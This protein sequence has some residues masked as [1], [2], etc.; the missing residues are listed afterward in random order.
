MKFVA[1]LHLHSHY[2][3]AT[4]KNL[5]L[6][7]LSKWAQL[8]GVQVVGTGDIAHPG[9][10]A[11]M[12]AKLEPAEA[13]LFRLKAEYAQAVQEEVPAACGGPV[14]F[15]LAGEISS[16]YKKHDQVRKV[17][18][19]IFAP[20]L[21]AVARIQI[22]LEKIGN[23]R[24]DGRP[25]LGLPSRDLLEIILAV[26]PDCYL[27]PAHIWTPW[28]SLLG[29][30]SGYDSVEECFE[31]LTPHIFALETGLSSDPPM[32]WR[33]SALDDY[34]LVSNS[35]AHSPQKLAREANLFETELSYPA[36]FAA[37]K[38][39][40]PTGFRGTIEFFPEEGKYHL[41]GHRKCN[42]CWEPQTTLQQQGL[43]PVCG[44]KVTVGVYHRVE[45]L[46][47]QPAGRRPAN[48]PPFHSLIPLPEVLSEIHGVGPNSKRVG[49][50]YET[51]LAKLGSELSILL[52]LP[53]ETITQ[54]G[55]S[56]L[57]E[58][59]RR[60][61]QGQIR[62]EGGFDGQYGRIKLFAEG[63]KERLNSQLLLFAPAS[64]RPAK[65]REQP[66][67]LE[68]LAEAEAPYTP[69]TAPE[70][71][72]WQQVDLLG[73][74]EAEAA[75]ADT[76]RPAK[77]NRQQ[78]AAA[79]YTDG[80]L[81]IT[82]GPGTGKTR[83]LTYRIAQLI[84]QKG[85]APEKMLAITFTNKAAAEMAGRLTALLGEPV[86]GQLTIKTFHAWGG[87]VLRQAGEQIGLSPTFAICGD[88]ERRALLADAEPDL[89]ASTLNHYLAQLAEAKN[90]LLGP[91][92]PELEPDFSRVYRRYE[93]RLQANQLVD[94]DDLILKTV[95]LFERCPEILRAYQDR[96][97]WISVD[98]YQDINLAQYRLLR[99]LTGPE[100]NLCV[101][102]DP[103]Q[104]IYGFRGADRGYFLR[105]EQDYP[106]A[107]T[108]YL[109]Q[110]YRSSQMILNAASQVIDRSADERERQ[111]WSDFIDQ[112]KLEVY[113]APTAAAEA[114]YVVHSIERMVGGTSYFSLDSGRVD[115]DG[116]GRSFA[117]FAVL[118]RLN[119]LN[120]PLLEAF[121][122]SGIPF[123]TAG[124]APFYAQKEVKTILAYLWF[125]H[126]PHSS[127]HLE[128]ILGAGQ[129]GLTALSSAAAQ[130]QLS[131]G[132]ALQRVDQ[133][134]ALPAKSRQ[135]LIDL[136]AF[137]ARLKEAAGRQP[138]AELIERV[139]QYRTPGQA[140]TE[141]EQRLLRNARPFAA[142]LG[143]F[144][145]TTM[146]ENETDAYDPRAD[147][148]SLMTLHAAKGL[149]FPVV[150][151]IGCEENL[152]P[153]QLGGRETDREEE[154]RLFYV[155]LT[156]AQ[157][158]LVLTQART[159]FLF[160]QQYQPQPSPFVNDIEDALKEI[161]RPARP[162]SEKEKPAAEQ[163]KLF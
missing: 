156:R 139:Q 96:W 159:R 63:E 101:I 149:E 16:I 77:L 50:A 153:Y 80:P 161:R 108:I 111:I 78:Q 163:L 65:K 130:H 29:S 44:K 56:L 162:K 150:F 128:T 147:R 75:P 71:E 97:P 53:L 14:R 28:F 69:Q 94:F 43:C 19:V 8:K 66:P 160:G 117:D 5:N 2:S 52:D 98:E 36:I 7:Q 134:P 137:L 155:G 126:N 141:A 84:S 148:V 127:P 21:Q 46:A 88:D 132:E 23:I 81:I 120:R 129:T 54:A 145:E 27:I 33:V 60:M 15:M 146:L 107:K 32:N 157:Q 26:D 113:Q 100:S 131:L 105:F 123:Q 112:T 20:S 10:L 40:D 74:P 83:T 67:G 62:A 152:L 85:V 41:D 82:A 1:D 18:N 86:A 45:T 102:G 51:L 142:R 158:K 143:A 22:E 11:E 144:L 35:D 57:A 76:V 42:I 47:D 92:G 121:E 109:R 138:V 91:D 119:A 58:G 118:Y 136:A 116:A 95:R 31:D 4:S 114:E 140:P 17:H 154:R 6:E 125:L 72:Q 38:G 68:Y 135:R 122:R 124:R 79:D 106:T 93:E 3:R 55:D 39:D 59:I 89:A 13:G 64:N 104:A 73:R 99:L 87:M 37:L 25:I 61:R 24:S 34:T 115:D 133:L 9:W 49:R 12:E 70:A 90:R 103:D 151:I 110:N 48:R 30:K